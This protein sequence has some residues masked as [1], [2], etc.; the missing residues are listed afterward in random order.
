M[1]EKNSH[2]SYCGHPFAPD[3]PWPRT[4]AACMTRSYLG[5]TPVAAILVPVGAGLLTVRR[6]IEPRLGELSLPGGFVDL[7][8]TWQEA[9]AREVRE[10]TGA[11]I[12]A[13]EIRD[14]CAIST[15]EGL[16]IIFGVAPPLAA[17]PILVPNAEVSELIVIARAVPLAFAPETRVVAAYFART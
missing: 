15:A 3:Q 13:R 5:P 6:A 14:L 4:C 1:P 2:C 17:P 9:G 7:G 12:D 8:E 10:E 16:V 11:A